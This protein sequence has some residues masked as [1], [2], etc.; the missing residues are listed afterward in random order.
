M[1][2]KTHYLFGEEVS[3]AY[4]NEGLESVLKL[5]ESGVA[6]AT[7]TVIEGKTKSTELMK[8]A[9]GWFEHVVITEEE[10]LKIKNYG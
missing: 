1:E 8:E 7:F 5:I 2:E 9:F 4:L 3:N 10:Y 6:Y